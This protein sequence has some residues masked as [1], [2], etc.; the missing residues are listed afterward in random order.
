MRRTLLLAMVVTLG[1]AAGGAGTLAWQSLG[2]EPVPAP[3]AAVLPR[4][5]DAVPQEPTTFLAWIPR[6]LPVGFTREVRALAETGRITQVAEEIS[7]LDRSWSTS[8]ELVDDPPRSYR[9]PLD[10][11]AIDPEGFAPFLPPTDR[12]ALAAVAEGKAILGATSAGLRGL[13]PGAELLVAGHR[14]EVAAVLPDELVGAAELV[15]STKVGRRIGVDEPR[16]LLIQS[17]EAVTLTTG[18]LKELLRPLLPASLGDNR[19]VQVRA[20]GDTPFFRAGDAVLPPVLVKELFGE[21][22]ARPRKGLTGALEIEP[23]WWQANIVTTEIPL[24]GAVTCHRAIVEQLEGTMRSLQEAGLSELVRSD[25]GCWVPRFVASD[26][27]NMI[28]Y[29]SW[30]IAIDLNL[31]GNLRGD[32]PHQDPRLV[33]TFEEWGFQWGGNWLVPDGNHFEYRRTP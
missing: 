7:W 15:V 14:I 32:P 13:G 24:L 19:V 31:E 33:A 18:G 25:H 2:S 29:H 12:A 3:P 4:V 20:P 30:G 8:G 28:S 21:F 5:L 16:Y 26:P 22:A 10:T 1:V 9:I 17:A 6:G 23:S 27:S 11:A